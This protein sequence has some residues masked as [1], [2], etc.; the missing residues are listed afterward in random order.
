MSMIEKVARAIYSW[1]PGP[2]GTEIFDEEPW[3]SCLSAARAS[4]EAM[5]EPT[6]EM[7]DAVSNCGAMWKE[8]SST[9]VWKLMIDGA[10]ADPK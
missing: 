4:L 10:L 1:L 6:E 9:N 7:Y 3:R 5:R 2:D 8:N